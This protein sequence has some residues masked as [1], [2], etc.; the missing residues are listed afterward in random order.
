MI[1]VK[2]IFRNQTMLGF[3]GSQTESHWH[4]S[5]GMRDACSPQF[6]GAVGVIVAGLGDVRWVVQ[7]QGAETIMTSRWLN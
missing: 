1:K 5:F 7:N 6:R 3:L 2:G 4:R